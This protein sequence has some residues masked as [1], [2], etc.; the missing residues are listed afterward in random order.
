M[1]QT[2]MPTMHRVPFKEGSR[3][4]ITN[5]TRFLP[6]YLKGGPRPAHYTL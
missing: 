1:K 5:K 2:L 3:H 4:S 6:R